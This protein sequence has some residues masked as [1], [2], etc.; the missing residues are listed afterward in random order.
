MPPVVVNIGLP[1]AFDEALAIILKPSAHRLAGGLLA[2]LEGQL[3][4]VGQLPE[5]KL[6]AKTEAQLQIDDRRHKALARLSEIAE[7]LDFEQQ[8]QLAEE[9]L[10]L[11]PPGRF[12]F[13]ALPMAK[14][15]FLGS[16]MDEPETPIWEM[17][18]QLLARASDKARLFEAHPSFPRIIGDLSATEA[19][20]LESM[21]AGYNA[22]KP[23]RFEIEGSAHA[24]G[25]IDEEYCKFFF[26]FSPDLH[27]ANP[28]PPEGIEEIGEL[29]DFAIEHLKQL[30][31]ITVNQDGGGK[32]APKDGGSEH[33]RFPFAAY[34]SSMGLTFMNAVSAHSE[35]RTLR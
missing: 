5:E 33:V 3:K 32:A 24:D 26:S 8:R 14:R 13:P 23:F 7:T 15:I 2:L 31:L 22:T 28:T 1:K 27:S 29:Y 4:R 20:L 10:A 21:Y 9:A 12:V 17:W 34:L 35:K 25:A 6:L 30:G 16:D 11:V 19:D 18:K